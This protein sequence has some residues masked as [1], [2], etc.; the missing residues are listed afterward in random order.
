MLDEFSIPVVLAF[1]A[2]L[3][4]GALLSALARAWRGPNIRRK[5]D[6]EWSSERGSV[7]ASQGGQLLGGRPTSPKLFRPASRSRP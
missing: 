4:L 6:R 2:V 3:A 7:E 1:F 5:H